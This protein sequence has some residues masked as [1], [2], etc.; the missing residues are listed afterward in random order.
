MLMGFFFWHCSYL[1]EHPAMGAA[2]LQLL[3]MPYRSLPHRSLTPMCGMSPYI[4]QAG[5][6][7]LATQCSELPT[8]PS[9]AASAAPKPTALVGWGFRGCMPGLVSTRLRCRLCR[10]PAWRSQ[11]G[12]SFWE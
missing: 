12:G 8:Q 9:K 4:S 1:Q 11:A 10:P 7:A 3:A 5:V 2:A 6:H